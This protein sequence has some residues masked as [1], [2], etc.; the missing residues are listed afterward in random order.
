MTE[1]LEGY[2]RGGKLMEAI[3]A[4]QAAGEEDDEDWADIVANL[5]YHQPFLANRP[6][7]PTQTPYPRNVY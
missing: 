7:Q 5:S 1:R 2:L 4:L 3:A 6:S